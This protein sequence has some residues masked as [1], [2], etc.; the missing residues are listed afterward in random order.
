[1]KLEGS[2][3]AGPLVDG[4]S[5]MCY[6]NPATGSSFNIRIKLSDMADVTVRLFDLE[7]T[8]VYTS[9]S[10]HE[11][12]GDVPFEKSVPTA[13]LAS[14]IYLCHVRVQGEGEDWSGS[15]K[16]AILK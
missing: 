14:G 4:N 1:M 8:E 3:G 2:V 16:V 11:W 12:T 13:G 6:P 15:K 7:G 5:M 9:T 10:K